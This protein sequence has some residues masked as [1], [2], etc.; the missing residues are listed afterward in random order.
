MDLVDINC[1]CAAKKVIDAFQSRELAL[2]LAWCAK[3]K[4]RLNKS[5]VQHC[6]SGFLFVL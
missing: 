5:K 4:S 6:F 2:A 1:F 3:K